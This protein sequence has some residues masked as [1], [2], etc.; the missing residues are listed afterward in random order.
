M[1]DKNQ[2]IL[3]N[4]IAQFQ[5]TEFIFRGVNWWPLL[6]IQV[7]YQWHLFCNQAQKNYLII[8]DTLPGGQKK[9]ATRFY[10]P[11][12]HRKK[13]TTK[14][15]AVITDRKNATTPFQGED[16]NI[17]TQPFLE[18]FQ[19]QKIDFDVFDISGSA[20]WNSF[21]LQR[22]KSYRKPNIIYALNQDHTFRRQIRMLS[23]ALKH[24]TDGE[25]DLYGFLLTQIVNNEV[26]YEC[27]KD[28]FKGGRCE[29]VL[30]YCFYN[31]TMQAITRAARALNLDVVEYQH[32]QIRSGHPAYS[33]WPSFST[34]SDFFP[35]TFWAWRKQD[36]E[37]IAK[38]WQECTTCRAISGGHLFL[39]YF[40]PNTRTVSSEIQVLIS[41]QGIGLPD[42]VQ[43]VM[44]QSKQIHFHLKLH[45][46][47]PDSAVWMNDLKSKNPECIHTQTV[48]ALSLYE[49]CQDKQFHLTAY[50]G[51]ALEAEYFGLQNIIVGAKGRKAYDAEISEQRYAYVEHAEE[52]LAVLNH[53]FKS[54]ST[55]F[56]TTESIRETCT[57]LFKR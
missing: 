53:P 36:A 33:Q 49:A 32:S 17:Y 57:E 50:S 14:K 18:E 48:N 26:Q 35:S 23:D 16:M 10:W 30:L 29:V 12:V 7:C 5:Q 45:P 51:S 1:D 41:L 31:N 56:P 9:S 46:R 19:R 21:D 44:V 54:V 55:Q 25:L 15:I 34:K 24:E 2:I 42:F 52:L 37:Y 40:K 22:E 20:P 28:F 27:F 8:E 39:N 3:D 11:F 38:V 4:W 6:K 43:E 47:Y 13:Y